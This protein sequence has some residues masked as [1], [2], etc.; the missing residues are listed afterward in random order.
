MG[1]PTVSRREFFRTLKINKPNSEDPIDPLFEKYSRKT[2]GPRVYRNELVN[3]NENNFSRLQ[4]QGD[5]A[6]VGNITSGLVPYT[7]SWTVNEA[8]YLAKRIGFGFKKT[9]V[10]AYVAAGS[11]DAAVDIVL[12]IDN[13]PPAPPVVWYTNLAADANG[14]A[15]GADWTQNPSPFVSTAQN[16]LQQTSNGHRNEGLRRWLFGLILNQDKTIKEK[17]TWFWYHFIPI[18]F[19]SVNNAPYGRVAL[20]SARLNYSYFKLLRDNCKG[21]FK[22][23]IKSICKHPAMMYYLNNQG[24]TASAPNEN[25]ARELLEL[26]TLGKDPASQ[27]TQSDIVE[28]AKVLTGWKIDDVNSVSITQLLR[29]LQLLQQQLMLQ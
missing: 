12:N 21:N 7:G 1:A 14:L 29:L 25:F 11:A 15:Y 3:Y 13:T 17:M 18:D 24:N 26:F 9:D 4:D 2:L 22:T 19:D 8:L 27:Y 20:N 16:A 28:A 10:D 5:S 6:R 23:L